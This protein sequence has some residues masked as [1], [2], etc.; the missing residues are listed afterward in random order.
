LNIWLVKIGE[1]MPTDGKNVRLL[2]TALLAK[3]LVEKGHK[4][5]WW[6]ST[7]NHATKAYRF[8][9]NTS[10]QIGD[11]YE[12]KFLHSIPYRK[13]VS[14]RRIIN[15]MGVARTF[16][17]LANRLTPPDAIVCCLPTL[18]LCA[19]AVRYGAAHNIPVIIDVRDLWPDIFLEL[20]PGWMRP[21]LRLILS[22]MFHLTGYSCADASAI[23]GI[24]PDFV[25]WGLKYAKRKTTV[26]D[27]CFPLGYSQTVPS[28]GEIKESEN[29]WEKFGVTPD[30]S[31]FISCYFGNFGR[32]SD[33]ETIIK[34]ARQ[35]N[36][37]PRNFLFVLCGTGDNM[38]YY[39]NLAKDCPN[40]VFPGWIGAADIW[41][42][43]R[44]S[45]VGL[46]PYRNSVG[47]ISNLPN[48]PIEYMSAGLPIVTSVTGYLS[49][50]IAEHNCGANYHN[51]A[52]LVQ[53]LGELYNNP[54]KLEVLSQNS[55][56]LYQEKFTAEKIYGDMV[57]Y[58]EKLV[59][60]KKNGGLNQAV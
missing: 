12:I 37:G 17:I 6:A 20:G 53:L 4:V 47:F 30:K 51:A 52:E 16:S 10:L 21:L 34:A 22:P 25:N 33:F 36:N 8:A 23:V 26:F 41:T 58:L 13:N 14:L 32:H 18:E 57:E 50:L 60:S 49:Q 46:A 40:V 2:R 5:I 11:N 28:D 35:L 19:A 24:T 56:K 48:K 45:S 27:Q 55:F 7:F 15:H 31:A 3:T 39:R 9:E 54:Q 42:L 44:M 1:S 59:A 38:N 43:M 29:K